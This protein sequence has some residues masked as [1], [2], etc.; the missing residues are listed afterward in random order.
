MN[1]VIQA[2]SRFRGHAART[3]NY[4]IAKLDEHDGY[5]LI[6]LRKYG[7]PRTS[8]MASIPLEVFPNHGLGE[9]DIIRLECTGRLFTPKSKFAPHIILKSF[10]KIGGEL[11]EHPV[12][13]RVNAL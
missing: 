7:Q 9:R 12:R 2:S 6:K 3:Q 10:E 11:H 4:I 1:D 5:L 8:M 13:Q